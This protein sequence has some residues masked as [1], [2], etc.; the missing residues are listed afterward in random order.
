MNLSDEEEKTF[1][2]TLERAGNYA[3]DVDFGLD[4]V[5]G[6]RVDEPEPLGAGQGP[7]ASKMLATAVGDC[8]SASLLFCLAKARADV[9]GMKTSVEGKLVRNERGRWRVAE[10]SVELTPDVPAENAA[11]LNRCIDL[12]E[13]FCTVGKSVE[14][15]IPLRIKVNRPSS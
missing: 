1:S 9:R 6:L 5:P 10:L 12:F 8:L 7:N 2:V 11:Q 14:Q 13:D 3:F 15:G 4:G